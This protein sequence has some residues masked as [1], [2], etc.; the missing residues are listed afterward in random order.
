M[1]K[2]LLLAA[3]IAGGFA[4]A[5]AAAAPLAPI[6]PIADAGTQI[7]PVHYSGYRHRHR[8]RRHYRPRSGFSVQLNFGTAPRYRHAPR[9]RRYYEPRPVY[10]AYGSRH[11][12]WCSNRYRSYRTSDGTYQPYHGGRRR[13]N[14]PYDGI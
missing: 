8:Q 7:E 2:T 12:N 10:R 3:M 5:P 6:A 11:H 13:C 1:F 14:S 9:Y 4:V